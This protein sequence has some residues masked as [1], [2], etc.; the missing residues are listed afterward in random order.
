MLEVTHPDDLLWL[1]LVAAL[2]M[3]FM[4]WGIGANDVANSFGTAFGA[5]ALTAKQV[6]F[7]P[8]VHLAYTTL[9]HGIHNFVQHLG[10]ANAVQL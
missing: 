7:F 5:K 9:F 1:V 6:P 4:A 10:H 2:A 8:P 3:G